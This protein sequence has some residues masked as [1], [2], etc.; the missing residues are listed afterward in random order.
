MTFLMVTIRTYSFLDFL[1]DLQKSISS[2]GPAD[3]TLW[4]PLSR[5]QTTAALQ[6][7]VG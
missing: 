7:D 6:L 5:V 3:S 1:A 2:A 4:G